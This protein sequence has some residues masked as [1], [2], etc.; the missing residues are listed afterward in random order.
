MHG[1]F[2]VNQPGEAEMSSGSI[3]TLEARFLAIISGLT[4]GSVAR[5]S[6]VGDQRRP[7]LSG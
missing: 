4:L 3:S 7:A 6:A 1:F 2:S 5:I